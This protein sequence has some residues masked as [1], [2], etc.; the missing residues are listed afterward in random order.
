[1]NFQTFSQ[2]TD[3]YNVC[4]NMRN[5]R[6]FFHFVSQ[7]PLLLS[8]PPYFRIIFTICK[9]SLLTCSLFTKILSIV[10]YSFIPACVFLAKNSISVYETT[11]YSWF[12][13]RRANSLCIIPT[14][15][16]LFYWV[17]ALPEAKF[18][19]PKTF[20]LIVYCAQR[21]RRT[22]SGTRRIRNILLLYWNR[23]DISFY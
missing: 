17:F 19:F 20:Q 14:M 1:M 15:I 21:L 4:G 11:F 8:Q 23:T 22:R 10:F 6:S 7:F 3:P 2:P 9:C 5:L 13:F 16:I 12:Q 18:I